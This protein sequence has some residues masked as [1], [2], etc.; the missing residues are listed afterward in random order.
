MAEDELIP[1]HI[2][3]H[4]NNV[5]ETIQAV[6]VDDSWLKRCAFGTMH[7]I[8]CLQS[9]QETFLREGV[10][11]ITV[12]FLGSLTVLLEFQYEE[13]M[14][15]YFE[16]NWLSQWLGDIKP[17]RPNLFAQERLAWLSVVGVP[18]HAWLGPNFKT[19]SERFGVVISVD[20]NTGSRKKLDRGRILVSTKFLEPNSKELILEVNGENFHITIKEESG[21]NF[22]MIN[23]H[24][25]KTTDHKSDC[26]VIG[27]A[28]PT[29]DVN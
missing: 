25:R 26:S 13:S 22:S 17:W 20:S 27:G 19:I 10:F 18:L 21:V 5:L 8:S 23:I 12:R 29:T 3:K 24:N 11:Y 6:E 28:S 2:V 14:L 7:H 15:C 1:E 4:Q 9:L 16:N